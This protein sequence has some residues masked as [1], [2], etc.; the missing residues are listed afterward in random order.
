MYASYS[1][2][3]STRTLVAVDMPVAL[4]PGHVRTGSF[5]INIEESYSIFFAL[6]LSRYDANCNLNSVP[7]TVWTLSKDGQVA[8]RS[9]EPNVAGVFLGRF[10][11]EKGTYALDVDILL[12]ASC[13]SSLHPR[14]RV[15][16]GRYAYDFWDTLLLWVCMLSSGV[17]GVLLAIGFLD[18]HRKTF[19]SLVVTGQ[20]GTVPARPSWK[21]RRPEPRRLG[22]LPSFSLVTVNLFVVLLTIFLVGMRPL[23]PFGLPA[24]ILRQGVRARANPGMEPLVVRIRLATPGQRPDLYIDSQL[25]TWEEFDAALLAQIR[26]RPLI[27]PVYVQGDRDMDWRWAAEVIGRIRGVP[28][29]VILVT[30]KSMQDAAQSSIDAEAAGTVAPVR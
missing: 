21:R 8:A 22:G 30:R 2:W 20:P 23:I 10:D 11:S 29:E 14:L 13:F 15:A 12:G 5:P 9:R 1:L 27:W 16:A 28:A 25:V 18:R 4:T 3:L 7:Q 24:R 17:G 19:P 26:R 6:D